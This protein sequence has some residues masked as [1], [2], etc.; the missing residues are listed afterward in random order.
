MSLRA[1][2][3]LVTVT[4]VAFALLAADVGAYVALRS[5]LLDRAM[6]ELATAAQPPAKLLLDPRG[7][8]RSFDAISR[9]KLLSRAG[10]AVYNPDGARV[11]LV[12]AISSDN[13]TLPDPVFP[14]PAT[15]PRLDPSDALLPVPAS[16]PS[17]T[18]PAG[19]GGFDYVM[20]S[21]ASTD[22]WVV[23]VAFPL[24]EVGATLSQLALIEAL[25]TLVVLS[26]VA[27][28]ARRL[29]SLALRPL[30]AIELTAARIAAGE[31]D[32][33]VAPANPRTEVGRLGTALNTMLGRIQEALNAREASEQRLRRLV[34]DASHELRTPLTSIRGYAEL[35]RR[36]ADDRP[37]D[38]ARAMRGIELEAQRMALLVDELLLLARL[39]EGQMP[40]STDV[41]LV[42]IVQAAVEAARV[43]EPDRRI[44]LEVP[45]TAV[46]RSDGVRLRQVIDNLL[47]NVRV[48]TPPGS[49]ARVT[50]QVSGG[51]VR[52]NVADFGPGMTEAV[53]VHAFER[54]YRADPSRSRDSGGSGLGLAIVSAIVEG[55]GGTVAVESEP[56]AGASF[57]VDLPASTP[58]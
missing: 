58:P 31:I 34:T 19:A 53:R 37:E 57:S 23:L 6:Q 51:R 20:T 1:R 55:Y 14:D 11:T 50:V 43:V 46:V 42:P 18:V 9:P 27:F 54:F 22:G 47:A 48:H 10:Y 49:P 52:L 30:G 28:V 24:D 39:D 3:V 35:F 2:L 44:D 8:D 15:V 38:L 29:V 32:Q 33:R 17:I 40:A 21:L 16:A 4:A 7:V 5:S 45:G 13:A 12:Q 25:V 26:L 36:G 56:G 41:D